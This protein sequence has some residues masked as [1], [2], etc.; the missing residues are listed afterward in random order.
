MD[1]QDL[2]RNL[3]R[4]GKEIKERLRTNEVET[5]S[6][7]DLHILEVQCYLLEHE[8]ARM[9]DQ[10]PRGQVPPAVPPFLPGQD[11]QTDN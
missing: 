8:V 3:V 9:K 7:A 1:L 4:Q 11:D 6:R 5:V 10:K 2:I